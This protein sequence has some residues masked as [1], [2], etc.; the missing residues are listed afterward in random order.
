MVS[1]FQNISVIQACRTCRGQLDGIEQQGQEA[2]SWPLN[3]LREEK[4]HSLK[5]QYTQDTGQESENSIV[6]SAMCL[7]LKVKFRAKSA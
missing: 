4:F 6:D 5:N 7:A 2:S 1:L 3:N